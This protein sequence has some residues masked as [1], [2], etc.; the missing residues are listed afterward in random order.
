M[1][2]FKHFKGR[3]CGQKFFYI[4]ITFV[5]ITWLFKMNQVNV[6]DFQDICTQR[7]RM[8]PDTGLMGS[9]DGRV[10]VRGAEGKEEAESAQLTA[11]SHQ[12]T[13][14][15]SL[16]K[17]HRHQ[18]DGVGVG[19]GR[20]RRRSANTL[21]QSAADSL[22]QTWQLVFFVPHPLARKLQARPK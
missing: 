4:N 14:I 9:Q 6:L 13:R 8:Q 1:F 21:L 15:S 7:R 19:R 18:R 3:Y 20:T 5:S 2:N 17:A 16:T 11:M 22:F 10:T 12:G